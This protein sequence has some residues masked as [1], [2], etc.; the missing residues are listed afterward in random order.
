MDQPPGEMQ[1]CARSS[2]PGFRVEYR[3]VGRLL[4]VSWSLGGTS[5]V[6]RS[7]VI[8]FVKVY[9]SPSCHGTFNVLEKMSLLEN[10]PLF[11]WKSW[12]CLFSHYA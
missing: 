2:G 9:G 3:H 5:L 12:I 8:V 7:A 6:T 4:P 1:E 11:P 10:M